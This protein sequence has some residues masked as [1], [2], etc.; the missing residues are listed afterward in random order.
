MIYRKLQGKDY[1]SYVFEFFTP[2]NWR[3]DYRVSSKDGESLGIQFFLEK[4]DN[5]DKKLGKSS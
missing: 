1:E 4:S 2:A 5:L 3:I